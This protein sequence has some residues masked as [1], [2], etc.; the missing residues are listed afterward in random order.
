MPARGR[1]EATA[2]APCHVDVA[3]GG[4]RLAAAHEGHD[5]VETVGPISNEE[6][7]SFRHALE[8]DDWMTELLSN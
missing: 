5:V 6:I 2:L 7:D 8:S 1:A 3:L 4:A